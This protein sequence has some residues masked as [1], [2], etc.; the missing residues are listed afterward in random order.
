M[1]NKY[2]NVATGVE[3]NE[4]NKVLADGQ[5]EDFKELQKQGIN[6]Q[7]KLINNATKK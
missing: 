6:T 2:L 5:E 1:L 7:N 4:F 3:N